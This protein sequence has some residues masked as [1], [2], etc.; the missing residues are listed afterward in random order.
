MGFWLGSS[1]PTSPHSLACDLMEPLRPWVEA[2]VVERFH[3]GDFDLRHFSQRGKACLFGKA[4]R[5]RYYTLWYQQQPHWARLM[6][7]H[8]NGLARYLS[9]ST[10]L[11]EEAA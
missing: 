3:T 8:A 1:S 6:Q 2:W 11:A 4:G 7:R 5:E 9:Q 10:P